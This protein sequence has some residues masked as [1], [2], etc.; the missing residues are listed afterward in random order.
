MAS[1]KTLYWTSLGLL[2]LSFASSP[3]LGLQGRVREI[4]DRICIRTARLRA[5]ADLTLGQSRANLDRMKAAEARRA[6]QQARMQAQQAQVRAVINKA[7]M[8]QVMAVSKA[9]KANQALRV[10]EVLRENEIPVIDC[11]ESRVEFQMPEM[12]ET[13][14][15]VVSASHDPI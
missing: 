9:W 10:K 2:L 15:V 8:K 11:P 7:E 12:P 4:A 14:D 13:P 1:A 6:A 3:E 5:M